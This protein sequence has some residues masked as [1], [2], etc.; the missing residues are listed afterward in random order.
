MRSQ[1]VWSLL[2][3]LSTLAT[4][5]PESHHQ[6]LKYLRGDEV[7]QFSEYSDAKPPPALYART[8]SNSNPDRFLNDK[9]KSGLTGNAL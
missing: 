7:A 8:N 9:T 6:L 2:G 3:L 1:S 5:S 4:A